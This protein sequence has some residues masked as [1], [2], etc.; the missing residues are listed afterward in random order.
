MDWAQLA[1]TAGRAALVYV[2]MLAVIRLL[3]KRTVGN[4]TVFDLLVAL[5]LGEV[6]D[7]IIYGDVTMAQGMTAIVVVAA[8]KY[9]TQWLTY[10]SPTLNKFLEGKPTEI[11]RHGEFMRDALR[12]EM[13]HEKEAMAS[14]RLK[15][16]TDIREV[17]TAV[18]EVDGEISVLKE[19]WAEPLQRA[20]VL[21]GKPHN[22][23]PPPEKRTDTPEALGA[24]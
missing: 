21:G 12:S 2:V 11:V 23:E 5:M 19:E 8:A 24:V 17:K 7:E 22:D 18:L 9:A 4:F 15:G 20:D 14:L 13:I 1:E 6:V 16:I 10:I 3:G